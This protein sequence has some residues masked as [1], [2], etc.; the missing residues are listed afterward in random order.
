MSHSQFDIGQIASA[1][2]G[3][4]YTLV[5]TLVDNP[6]IIEIT[7]DEP[8]VLTG[9]ALTTGTMDFNATVKLTP[10]DGSAPQVLA[11]D[12]IQAGA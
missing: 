12:F 3:D 8:R 4:P 7:F 11:R 10:A 9:L 5:R 6:A 1:F 2:D